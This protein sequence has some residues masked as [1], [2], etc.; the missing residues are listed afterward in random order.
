MAPI[1]PNS[2]LISAVIESI[3]PYVMQ[4]GFSILLLSVQKA[5][6]RKEEKFLYNNN[7]DQHMKA[8]AS[9]VICNGAALKA[10]KKINA[11]VKKVSP[12]LWKVLGFS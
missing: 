5:S 10:G 2:A 9:D 3:E 8:I 1:I 11:E 4:E 7:E 12:S 6:P